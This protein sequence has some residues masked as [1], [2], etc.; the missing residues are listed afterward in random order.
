[1]RVSSFVKVTAIDKIYA[2]LSLCENY[3]ID[4]YGKL[5]QLNVIQ[6]RFLGEVILSVK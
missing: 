5:H 1:M 6:N 4:K 2:V 3:V